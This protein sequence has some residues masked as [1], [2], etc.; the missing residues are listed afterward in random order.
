M[1]KIAPIFN[2]TID[3]KA[4]PIIISATLSGRPWVKVMSSNQAAVDNKHAPVIAID[5]PSGAGK[6][7]IAFKLAQH[8]NWPILDSGAIYRALGLAA[9]QQSIDFT[10]NP[11]LVDLAL[12]LPLSFV[13]DEASGEV[14]AQLDG[15]AVGDAIRTDEAGQA[16]SQVA[17]IPAVRSALLQRQRDFQRAPGLI[18]DGRDMGT[19]VFPQTPAKI[20]LTA[21]AETRA[22][23]RFEQLKEKGIDASLCALLKSIQ[24]RDERDRTRTVAPLVPAEG[25]F[26]VDSSQL[27]IDDVFSQVL[28]FVEKTL[29]IAN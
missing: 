25:A 14:I 19:V 5:G 27:S 15:V 26:V 17:A 29:S 24:E 7:T 11:Q 4:A 13:A 16:A 21:S 12:N 3:F 18:A 23:R 1:S 20:F 6:G 10:D 2:R 9:K 8:F 22:N 28:E